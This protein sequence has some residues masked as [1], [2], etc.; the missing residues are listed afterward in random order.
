MHGSYFVRVHQD[1][2]DAI[3]V[4]RLAPGSRLLVNRVLAAP[5]GMRRNTVVDTY[6]Q[7]LSDVPVEARV[8]AGT[9]VA[10]YAPF[11]PTQ[12]EQIAATDMAPAGACSPLVGRV[13]TP[14]S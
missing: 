5:L 7:L 2:R 10:N 12:P 13:L 1:L 4:G 9:F 8:G 14:C 6:E 3:L 11:G